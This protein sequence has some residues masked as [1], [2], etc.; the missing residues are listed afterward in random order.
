[1]SSRR[2]L[3]AWLILAIAMSLN[4]AFRE[5][6]LRRAVGSSQADAISAALGAVIILLVTRPFFRALATRSLAEIVRISLLL[7]SLTVAFEFVFGRYVDGRSWEELVA[8]YAIW[9]GR[10]WPALLVLIAATPFLWGRWFRGRA[11]H[12]R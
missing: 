2:V 5:L 3:A 8:N 9:D 10:L 11:E 12:A 6:C 4:G 7:V 1:M